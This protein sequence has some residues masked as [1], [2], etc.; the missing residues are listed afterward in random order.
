MSKF[1]IDDKDQNAI[2]IEVAKPLEP[3]DK[4]EPNGK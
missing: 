1:G 3:K 4:K 2:I